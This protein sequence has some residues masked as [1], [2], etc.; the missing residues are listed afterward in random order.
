MSNT[1]Q[2][3]LQTANVSRAAAAWPEFV[4]ARVAEHEVERVQKRWSGSHLLHGRQP[5][6]DAVHFSSNDYLCLLGEQSLVT[7]QSTAMS[8]PESELLMSA[9]FLH[10][11]N[12]TSRLE[13]KL[14]AFAGAEDSLLCQSGWAANVGLLQS[15]ANERTPVYLD[16]LAHMSLWEGAHA[17]HARAIPFIH[18]DAEHAERQI[19]KDGPGII[20]VDAVYSTN[21]S[22]CPLTD[23]V[24]VAERTGSVLVV[25]ESHSLGTHGPAGAGLVAQL[26]LSHRVH[27]QTASLAKAFGGR[28]G[29][30]TCP[31]SFKGYFA[32]ESRP[33]IFSSGLLHHE[34]AWF[35]AAADFIVAADDRRARLHAVSSEVRNALAGLGYNVSAGSEQ[36][37]ALESG[38]EQQTLA[39]R[40]ALQE[41]GIFGAVFCAPA[42]AR[43]RALMRLTMNACLTAVEI[44]RLIQVCAEIRDEIGLASWRSTQRLR[45]APRA[46]L[47]AD[48]QASTPVPHEALETTFDAA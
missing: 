42:T 45:N 12:P 46:R 17:A 31:S 5:G 44:E 3:C 40:N 24:D 43:D 41:R 27:F 4:T 11:D 16:M 21:G 26:G 9:I 29:L 23:F 30:I 47:V 13:R 1:N 33:A 10:G 28:A 20:V 14:A 48:R 7:A 6:P 19:R 35:D 34:L 8:R 32:M 38:T 22:L 37:I 18:N 15:I 39:L 2:A 25:D 36:I